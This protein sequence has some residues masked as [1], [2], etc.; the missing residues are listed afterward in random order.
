MKHTS[1]IYCKAMRFHREKEVRALVVSSIVDSQETEIIMAVMVA[2]E[3]IVADAVEDQM[4]LQPVILIIK[5]KI[6]KIQ[7]A[8]QNHGAAIIVA[9]NQNIP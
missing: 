5:S 6:P 8:G 7:R 1:S 9:E 2:Y 4:V 3:M